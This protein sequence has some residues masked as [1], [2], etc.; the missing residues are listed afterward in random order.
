MCDRLL[1][2]CSV[3]LLVLLQAKI[4]GEEQ[5]KLDAFWKSLKPDTLEA[6][7]GQ[8]AELLARQQ[9]VDTPEALAS[10]PSLKVGLCRLSL[11]A[12]TFPCCLE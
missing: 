4:E 2:L 6:L 1:L 11:P 12:W 8:N 10:I 9:A 5:A 7:K 3:L